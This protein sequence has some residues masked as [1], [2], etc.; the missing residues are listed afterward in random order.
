MIVFSLFSGVACMCRVATR[1]A[2]RRVM[3]GVL[4]G[5]AMSAIILV[6]ILPHPQMSMSSPLQSPVHR[7]IQQQE[8]DY[9]GGKSL[10]HPEQ[11]NTFIHT[12]NSESNHQNSHHI[13]TNE[14]LNNNIQD[15]TKNNQYNLPLLPVPQ[16]ATKSAQVR[17]LFF[18]DYYQSHFRINVSNI[19]KDMPK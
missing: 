7:R 17:S 5:V 14:V 12:N 9:T 11:N 13:E 10:Q 6:A 19:F 4:V 18:L 1:A 8:T 2:G 15:K 16:V 3:A